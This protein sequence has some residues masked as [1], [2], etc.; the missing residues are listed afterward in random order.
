M[1]KYRRWVNILTGMK[2]A[3]QS[4][5]LLFS[6]MLEAFFSH[7]APKPEVS[8]DNGK[9]LKT[10]NYTEARSRARILLLEQRKNSRKLQAKNQSGWQHRTALISSTLLP[11]LLSC[12]REPLLLALSQSTAVKSLGRLQQK[13]PLH[14]VWAGNVFVLATEQLGLKNISGIP[15][16]QQSTEVKGVISLNYLTGC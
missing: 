5:Q 2:T 7:Q 3:V 8:W 6:S 9:V 12:M 15:L 10:I 4:L 14:P 16:L 13:S 11:R 1:G